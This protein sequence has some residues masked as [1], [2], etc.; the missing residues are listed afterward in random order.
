MS[1][2]NKENAYIT[3]VQHEEIIQRINDLYS[4][5]YL[6]GHEYNMIYNS[7]LDEY[8]HLEDDELYIYNNY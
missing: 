2:N 7:M 3:Q 6:T 1:Y 8:I 4:D 5:E